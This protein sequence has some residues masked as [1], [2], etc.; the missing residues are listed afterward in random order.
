MRQRSHI[1]LLLLATLSF[2]APAIGQSITIRILDGKTADFRLKPKDI[3]YVANRPWALAEQA[4]DDATS[5]FIQSFIVTYTGA[6]VGPFI[7]P[8]VN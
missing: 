1:P 3:V 5:A 7:T 8:I 4:L 2:C 6:K